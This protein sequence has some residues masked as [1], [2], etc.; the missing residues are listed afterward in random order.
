MKISTYV[1][2][3]TP[4][5]ETSLNLNEFFEKNETKFKEKYISAI[6]CTSQACKE[7][8]VHKDTHKIVRIVS[9]KITKSFHKKAGVM[10][11]LKASL[12][13]GDNTVE[14]RFSKNGNIKCSFGLSENPE[15]EIT[16]ISE[17][18]KYETKLKSIVSK[19]VD[20]FITNLKGLPKYKEPQ[21]VNMMITSHKL[22]NNKIVTNFSKLFKNLL[23]VLE[24]KK[25]YESKLTK[26]SAMKKIY[27]KPTVDANNPTI[28]LY[29]NGT[30]DFNGVKQLNR[31]KVMYELMKKEFERMLKANELTF[32]TVEN[33]PRKKKARSSAYRKN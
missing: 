6:L 25:G 18:Q 28:G 22:Y 27:F 23:R 4:Q 26:N 24:D 21:V 12:P 29:A 15:L 13:H 19:Y 9:S 8:D 33:K 16:N 10:C 11:R 3:L 14:I 5:K 17:I 20:E 30:L 32:K 7:S 2:T 31:V 1:C